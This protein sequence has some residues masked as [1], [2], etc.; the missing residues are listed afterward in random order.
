MDTILVV[1]IPELRLE[2]VY[3]FLFH[4]E[5]LGQNIIRDGRLRSKHCACNGNNT[6]IL[7]AER[8]QGSRW[9]FMVEV[10]LEVNHGL[11][12]DEHVTLLDH[13]GEEPVGVG[14]DKAKVECSLEHGEELG[15]A[16]VDV[17]WVYAQGCVV[18][19][20]QRDT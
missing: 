7:A 19:A 20:S 13:L 15:G 3:E 5:C 14:G 2:P 16:G 11:R 10:H 12:E 18:D 8:R 9:L 17:R 1:G 4:L 6:R